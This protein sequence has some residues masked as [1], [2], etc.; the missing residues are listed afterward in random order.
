MVGKFLASDVNRDDGLVVLIEVAGGP[1]ICDVRT[2]ICK[3]RW[4]HCVNSSN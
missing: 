4:R 2:A 1:H 3:Q